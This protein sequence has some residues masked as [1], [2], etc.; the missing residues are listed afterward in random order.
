MKKMLAPI[1]LA[2]LLASCAAEIPAPV[3]DTTI[4]QSTTAVPA[5]VPATAAPAGPEAVDFTFTSDNMPRLDGSTATR[6]L[7]AA[8][9]S[10]LLGIDAEAAEAYTEFSGTSNAY[11][12]LASRDADLLVVYEPQIEWLEELGGSLTFEMVPIGRDALVFLVNT[13][14]PVDSLTHGQIV[15]IYSGVVTNWRDVGGE[16]LGIR[17][18]QRNHSSG[19]QT[20]MDKLVMGDVPLDT[21]PYDY[22]IGE[23]MGLVSA[24]ASYDGAQSSIGYNVHYFVSQM[25]VNPNIKQLSVDGVAPTHETIRTGEYP[26]VNDFYV[27]ILR[28]TPAGSPERI[29]FDWLQGEAGQTLIERTGYVS[30]TG[31][32]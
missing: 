14:N 11:K 32:Q 29:L 6:P 13:L 21:P 28:D 2:A 30:M 16:N 18:F 7:A 26:F 27:V 23:M 4:A 5:S 12:A 17:A 1:A 10:A 24:V 9:V 20:L 19:S 31:G 22:V 3:Q 8:L 15:D 25:A